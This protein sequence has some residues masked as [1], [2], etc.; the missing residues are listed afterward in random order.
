MPGHDLVAAVLIGLG[1]MKVHEM[2][3]EF[4][5]FPWDH[6]ARIK[7]LL[8]VAAS[9]LLAWAVVGGEPKNWLV[10]GGAAAGVSA[11]S[12]AIDSG[13]RAWRD[14]QQLTV[15]TNTHRR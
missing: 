1:V 8:S 14:V 9:L 2:Y 4:L 5:P 15:R 3:Q 12:H 11:V 13:V 10:T 6:R 7:S